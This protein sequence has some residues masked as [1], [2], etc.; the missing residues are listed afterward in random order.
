VFEA[1]RRK[2][3]EEVKNQH[4]NTEEYPLVSQDRRIVDLNAACRIVDNC[5]IASQRTGA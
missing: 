1:V 3:T 5:A 2:P 4:P